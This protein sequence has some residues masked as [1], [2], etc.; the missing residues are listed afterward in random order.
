MV[1]MFSDP[2]NSTRQRGGAALV[3]VLAMVEFVTMMEP[4][5]IGDPKPTPGPTHPSPSPSPNPS[6]KPGGPGPTDPTPPQPIPPQ[7]TR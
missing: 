7:P 3:C 2:V 1:T 6:P 5:Q 4:R